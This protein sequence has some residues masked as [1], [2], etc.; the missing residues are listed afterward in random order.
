MDKAV[1]ERNAFHYSC[2]GANPQQAGPDEL[3]TDH[4]GYSY[5]GNDGEEHPYGQGYYVANVSIPKVIPDG[6]YVLGWVWFGGIGSVPVLGNYPQPPQPS[7]MGYYADQ[8]SCA[9]VRIEG[10]LALESTYYPAFKNDI[11][12]YNPEG[13][14]A[15]NDSPGICTVEPCYTPGIFQK[16]R[17]FKAG[18]Y[19]SPLTPNFY[20]S[21]SPSPIPSPVSGDHKSGSNNTQVV[22]N[23]DWNAYSACKCIE[24]G[25]N[26]D[27]STAQTAGSGCIA[28]VKPFEQPKSCVYKCCSICKF[29]SFWKTCSTDVMKAEN[30]VRR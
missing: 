3:Q 5:V 18:S 11:S 23:Y 28:A 2:W 15:A 4:F 26:C 6:D 21:V 1:H 30:C 24:R 14:L 8:W 29:F 17:N 13:C 12:Q 9:Y 27:A 7:P 10:G 20:A 25:E 22:D 19:P 16:P